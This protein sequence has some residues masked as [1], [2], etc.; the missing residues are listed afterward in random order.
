MYN[1]PEARIHCPDEEKF[2][3]VQSLSE[4]LAK[5]YPVV[6]IDGVR[7]LFPEGWGLFRASNTQAAIVARAEAFSAEKLKEYTEL[8]CE[9]Y[10][11]IR[12][13]EKIDWGI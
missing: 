3:V 12:P 9:L 7:V 11:S 10:S 5:D 8:L 13:G 2:K 6:T 4:I 1:T